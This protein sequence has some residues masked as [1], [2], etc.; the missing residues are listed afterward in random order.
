MKILIYINLYN[1]L[2]NIFKFEQ[3]RMTFDFAHGNLNAI[4]KVY[5]SLENIT[6]IPY[7]F[8]L[9]QA[10]PRNVDKYG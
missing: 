8:H 3:K 9:T 2:F 5:G 7:F 6:I 4:K 10:W 1:F